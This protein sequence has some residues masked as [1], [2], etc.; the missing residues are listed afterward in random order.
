MS[1][2]NKSVKNI[3][4]G[5]K[6]NT[7]SKKNASNKNTNSK[8][9]SNKNTNSKNNTNKNTVGNTNANKNT[10]IKTNINKNTTDKLNVDKKTT[11]KTNANKNTSSIK[12]SASN[13]NNSSDSSVNKSANGKTTSKKADSKK[14]TDNSNPV[15]NKTAEKKVVKDKVVDNSQSNVREFKKPEMRRKKEPQTPVQT[16]THEKKAVKRPPVSSN[17]L[18]GKEDSSKEN[19]DK[20][21][22]LNVKTKVIHTYE[23]E[24]T[25]TEKLEEKYGI[26]I[27]V[28]SIVKYTFIA[29]V[30]L[31]AI[32]YGLYATRITEVEVDEGEHYT[33]EE[34]KDFVI[35]GLLDNNAIYLFL[36]YRYSPQEEIPFVEQI[37]VELI[38]KNK[39]KLTA[40]DKNIIGCTDYMNQYLY[41]DKD[42]NFVE[43]SDVIKEDVAYVSGINFSEINLH[44]KMK[45]DNDG[46]FDT[47][48]SIT[49]Q[50]SQYGLEV[51]EINFDEEYNIT[52]ICGKVTVKLGKHET[53]DEQL[54]LIKNMLD[55]AKTNDMEGVLHLENYIEGQKN[56]IFDT[57]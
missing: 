4:T 8:N 57:K 12:T 28:F 30:V 25:F 22:T 47:I 52:L 53:Y 44:E 35:K 43:A 10:T 56:F 45:V 2:D 36:K 13:K 34:I 31:C 9:T 21:K 49:Q 5:Q 3:N 1:E 29:V 16:K 39:V 50:I 11:G 24:K 55:E 37:D 48:I 18:Q 42:G 51:S 6:K 15:E 27:N 33:E 7:T 46:L 14:V 23:P 17:N 26:E 40:Y 38:N 41:F 32:G 20:K 54:A 19:I